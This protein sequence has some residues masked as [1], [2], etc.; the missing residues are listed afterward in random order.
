MA[1]LGGLNCHN[2]KNENSE[3][4][5]LVVVKEFL[6][7]FNEQNIE[8][9]KYCFNYPLVRLSATGSVSVIQSQEE[10]K[11]EQCPLENQWAV[12]TLHSYQCIQSSDTKVHIAALFKR[13]NADGSWYADVPTFYVVTKQNDHWGIQIRSSYVA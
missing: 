3:E 11:E 13:Y 2:I 8:K 7:S 12:S 9:L 6:S 10:Y 1:T 4:Q 5:A